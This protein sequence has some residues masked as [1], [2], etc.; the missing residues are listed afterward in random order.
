M[1][2]NNLKRYC[3]IEGIG[4]N[5]LVVGGWGEV[6]VHQDQAHTT[7]LCLLISYF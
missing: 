3:D 5:L 4:T 1:I 6:C 2:G 7:D